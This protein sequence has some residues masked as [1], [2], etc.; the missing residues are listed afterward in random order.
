[1]PNSG[2]PQQI[3]TPSSQ[4]AVSQA[5]SPIHKL[6]G[7]SGDEGNKFKYSQAQNDK[8]GKQ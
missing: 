4:V 8:A 3:Y 7:L 5:Q 6:D 1:M 2:N